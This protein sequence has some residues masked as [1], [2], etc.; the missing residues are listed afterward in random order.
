MAHELQERKLENKS[1]LKKFYK[2]FYN[3]NQRKH[4]KKK[5]RNINQID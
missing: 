5:E 4:W 3:M 2:N 1:F